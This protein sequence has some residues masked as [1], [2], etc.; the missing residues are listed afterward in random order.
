MIVNR[1]F[2]SLYMSHYYIL[3]CQSVDCIE[4]KIQKN[5][6][7]G[8]TYVAI[9]GWE[10]SDRFPLKYYLLYFLKKLTKYENT[11]FHRDKPYLKD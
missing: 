5:M 9:E 10:I 3:Y 8:H 6:S 11:Q 1:V 2:H 4:K 7:F